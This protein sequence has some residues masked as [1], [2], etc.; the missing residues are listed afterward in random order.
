VCDT[1]VVVG[2]GRVLFA[3]NYDMDPNEAQLLEWHPR[4]SHPRDAT[5]RCTWISVPQVAETHAVVISRPFWMWGA[6]MGA[7]EHGVAIGNEAVFTNQ[8]YATSGLTGMDLVRLALERSVN[9]ADAVT[10]LTELLERHGQGGGCG[11]ERRSFTYHNSF[12]VADPVTA[13]VLE[14][15][16]ENWAVEQVSSGVRSVSNGLT[17]APFAKRYGDRLRTTVSACRARRAHTQRVTSIEASPADLIALLR[18]HGDAAWPHYS[19]V[20]GAMAAPCMHAGGILAASQTTASWVSELRPAGSLHWATATAAPCTSLF[21]PV[22]VD[23]PVELGTPADDRFDDRTIWWRHE[24]LHRAALRNLRRV[25]FVVER[26]EVQRRWLVDPP[27]SASAF[28]EADALVA[29]WTQELGLP[30]DVRPRW[31]RR[32]WLERDRRARLRPLHG[33]LDQVTLSNTSR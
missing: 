6:E 32:Y 15:A 8:P 3:K 12:V 24:R 21:K 28:S 29:R 20:N 16:G 13:F 17:I 30:R 9:A 22:R 33:P 19:P 26:D 25:G 1:V 18:S 7:N 11:H 27:S 14:T 31:V 2:D 4:R 23:E 10:V 5:L